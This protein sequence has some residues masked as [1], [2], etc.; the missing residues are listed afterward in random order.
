MRNIAPT[1]HQMAKTIRVDSN[2]TPKMSRMTFIVVARAQNVVMIR[3]QI[4]ILKPFRQKIYTR[5]T[6]RINVD[7]QMSVDKK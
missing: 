6:Q 1:T 2:V 5:C 3:A 4:G 7:A